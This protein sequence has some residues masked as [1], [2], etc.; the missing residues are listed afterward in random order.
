M[1]AKI[2]E[3]NYIVEHKHIIDKGSIESRK[4]LKMESKTDAEQL[5]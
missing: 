5:L 2:K 3:Y 4:I 1:D